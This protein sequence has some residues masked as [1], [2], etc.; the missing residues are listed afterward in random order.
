MVGEEEGIGIGLLKMCVNWYD[1]K[2]VKDDAIIG[3]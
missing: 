1:Y 3:Q 2:N